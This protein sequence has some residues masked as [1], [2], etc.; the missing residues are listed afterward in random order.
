M[1]QD[2]QENKKVVILGAGISGLAA[3]YALSKKGFKCTVIEKNNFVGGLSATFS[4]KTHFLDYGPH[5]FHTH[6]PWMVGFVENELGVELKRMPSRPAKILFDDKIVDYPIN[7]LDSLRKINW[8]IS[9]KCFVYYVYARILLKLRKDTS[10]NSFEDWVKN[11][12]GKYLFD[13]YFGPYVKKVWGVAAEDLDTIIARKRIPD[14]SFLALTLRALFG[15]KLGRKHSEDPQ[16][17]PSYYPFGGIG[18][19]SDKLVEHIKHRGGQIEL[20]AQV[21]RISCNKVKG[22]TIYYSC[23]EHQRIIQWDYLI[24][25]IPLNQFISLLSAPGSEKISTEKSFFLYRAT[26]F[27]YLFLNI[28]KVTEHP[29]IYFNDKDNQDLIFNR[30]YE[31]SNFTHEPYGGRN[32]VLCLE[33]TCYKDDETWRMPDSVLFEKCISFLEKKNFLKRENVKEILTKRIDTV[34]PVFKK[35][36]LS[37]LINILEYFNELGNIVTIGRQGLFSYTNVDHC[38]DMGLRVE[39]LITNDSLDTKEFQNIYH[40]YILE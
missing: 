2:K 28:D 12:F 38:L 23:N 30:M 15:V 5:N 25:T 22:N 4:Y 18:A 13:I 10:D 27:L 35:N 29:W 14:P 39:R 3:A 40:D 20:N 1:S 19:V 26:I 34:Y 21:E 31:I 7:I 36:Y 9:L 37:H 33:I 6:I 24:N 11:R 32:G 8:L 17:T 16:L